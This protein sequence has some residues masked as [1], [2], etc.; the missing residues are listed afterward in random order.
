[1]AQPLSV[2]AQPLL[3]PLLHAFRVLRQR[4]QLGQTGLGERRIR[5][6]LLVALAGYLQLA[7]CGSQRLA[8]NAGET[9][10]QL[11]LI[12]RPRE[13]PLLELARHRNDPL[14]R[15]G[16]VLACRSTAPGVRAR[17]PVCEHATRDQQRVLVRGT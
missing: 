13:A 12:R 4:A 5:G 8:V 9:I 17:P 16:D 11:E 7:P 2:D 3:F 10:Q 14:D 6:Q 15:G 1:M